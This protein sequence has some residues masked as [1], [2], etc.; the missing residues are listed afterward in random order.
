[1]T[2]FLVVNFFIVFFRLFICFMFCFINLF[3]NCYYRE[4][5]FWVVYIL[6]LVNLFRFWRI[7]FF[8]LFELKLVLCVVNSFNFKILELVLKERFS[9]F[10]VILV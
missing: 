6:L 5:S 10:F 8:Y 1:M 4:R 7:V 3:F 9:Y 2:G